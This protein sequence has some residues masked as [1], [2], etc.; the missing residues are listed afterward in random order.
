MR[1]FLVR[2]ETDDERV[3]VVVDQLDR[4]GQQPAQLFERDLRFRRDF[5]R[6]FREDPSSCA[7]TD[8]VL[9]LTMSA[10]PPAAA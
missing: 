6:V 4:A 9:A 8:F 5:R 10:R 7:S 3:V 2:P 1:D